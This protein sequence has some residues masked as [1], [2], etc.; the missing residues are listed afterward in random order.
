MMMGTSSLGPLNGISTLNPLLFDKSKIL[1]PGFPTARVHMRWHD[2]PDISMRNGTLLI[3]F[4]VA[5]YSSAGWFSPVVRGNVREIVAP[6]G[7]HTDD[8]HSMHTHSLS[9][10]I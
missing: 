7:P 10:F 8:I 4:G 3:K 1:R 2:L 5:L 9:S 6:C